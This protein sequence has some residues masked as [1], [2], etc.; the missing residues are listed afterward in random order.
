VNEIEHFSATKRL[1]QRLGSWVIRIAS[2][3]DVPDAP[4][5]FRAMSREA[6]LRL[7][8]FSRYTYTLETIIQ[9][10][11]QGI[12]ITSV[13][14]RTNEDLRPS[15]LIK[16][17]PRYV[18]HSVIMILRAFL[19]YKPLRFFMIMGSVP[20]T[21]GV[22][23][24]VRWL[25]FFME[26]TSRTRI[27]SLILTAILILMGFQL[28]VFGF[29]ADLLDVNRRMVEDLQLGMRRAEL[30]LPGPG[31]ARFVAGGPDAIGGSAP[32]QLPGA[33]G[34]PAGPVPGVAPAGADGAE[35]ARIAPPGVAQTA[36]GGR[37]A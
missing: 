36:A 9:A 22:L 13:P 1:L 7:N 8:V 17:V 3:T 18:S 14:I 2:K 20:F 4:S 24:G 12:T 11:R 31:R 25:I 37:D 21:L 16:S 26:G 30:S 27:P 29:V 10:G 5:G 35:A 6:A 28:W 15:R 34:A 32:A 33:A 19:T 23:L